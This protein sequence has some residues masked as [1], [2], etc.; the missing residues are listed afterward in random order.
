MLV[1]KMTSDVAHLNESSAMA[2]ILAHPCCRGVAYHVIFAHMNLDYLDFE[3][4]IAELEEKID[5]LRR[6]GTGQDLNLSEEVGRLQQKSQELTRTIFANLTAAA[7]RAIGAS[8]IAPV[9]LRLYSVY[10]Y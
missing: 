3:Q 2:R 9:Y 8:P 6:V 7:D 4:P 5:E 10:F 1:D